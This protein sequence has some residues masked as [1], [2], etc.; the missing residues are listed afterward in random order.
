MKKRNIIILSVVILVL[1]IMA[2]AAIALSNKKSGADVSVENSTISKDNYYVEKGLEDLAKIVK[3]AVENYLNQDRTESTDLRNKRLGKYFS[4]DS[5]AYGYGTQN[6]DA[7]VYKSSAK[8]T[9]VTSSDAEGTELCL[10]VMTET[11]FY[12]KGG[13]NS[14]TQSYWISLKKDTAGEYTIPYDIGVWE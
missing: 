10:I 2:I 12:F 8:V 14:E 1:V 11:T 4:S 9:S 7:T 3:P 13:S 5:P 6:I